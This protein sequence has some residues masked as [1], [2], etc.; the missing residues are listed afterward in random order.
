MAFAMAGWRVITFEPMPRNREAISTS[1]CL[2]RAISDR[3]HLEPV[4]L[5]DELRPGMS[6]IASAHKNNPGNAKMACAANLTCTNR[7]HKLGAE[8]LFASSKYPSANCQAVSL[9]TLDSALARLLPEG[10]AANV[11]AVKLDVEQHECE[12]LAGGGSLFSTFRPHFIRAENEVGEVREC[13]RRAAARHGY[14]I[15]RYPPD[16]CAD[17]TCDVLLVDERRKFKLLDAP[18][19]NLG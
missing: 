16:Q 19:H 5:T 14:R 8:H 15:A 4:A 7:R 11:L 12:V 6:C 10:R 3:V 1:L 18:A 17:R 9:S 13:Y 2:N